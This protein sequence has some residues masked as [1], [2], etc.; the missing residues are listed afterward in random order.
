MTQATPIG[1]DTLASSN[2]PVE[3]HPVLAR[4]RRMASERPSL[5]EAHSS[6]QPRLAPARVT[7][8]RQSS[9]AAHDEQSPQERTARSAL[10]RRSSGARCTRL[11]K[12]RIEKAAPRP[13]STVTGR[14]T[15]AQWDGRR[16]G[17][18]ADQ[19][20]SSCGTCRW[21]ALTTQT[22]HAPLRRRTPSRLR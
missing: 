21:Q 10:R 18:E 5:F 15:S 4:K 2:A 11:H 9:A 7:A 22:P 20:H 19:K 14:R 6:S 8:I 3:V 1:S 12:M 16:T 17:S 13:T